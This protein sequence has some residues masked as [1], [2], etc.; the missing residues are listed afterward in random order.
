M[1]IEAGGLALKG[2]FDAHQDSAGQFSLENASRVWMLLWRVLKALGVDPATMVPSCSL[3]VRL[4]LKHG[5]GSSTADQT[6]NPRFY[7]KV[8][9]W[10]TDWTAPEARV[11]EFP[12][13]LRLS[14][15]R[16]S[17]LLTLAAQDSSEEPLISPSTTV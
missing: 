11:T 3:P 17:E 4:S 13:W 6:S 9:G 2:P 5:R 8:M 14:R 12:A 1:V 16:L 7:E 10:P 15:G